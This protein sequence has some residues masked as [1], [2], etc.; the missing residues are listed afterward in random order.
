MLS[1]S[2]TEVDCIARAE[3]ARA[4]WKIGD[5]SLLAQH[6]RPPALHDVTDTDGLMRRP[7]LLA[8]DDRPRRRR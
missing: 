2:S 4:V 3:R 1:L 6:H 8:D 5:R 7:S